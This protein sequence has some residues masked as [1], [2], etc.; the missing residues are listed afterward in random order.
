MRLYLLDRRCRCRLHLGK[1]LRPRFAPR[2]R[3]IKRRVQSLRRSLRVSD[4]RD[5]RLEARHLGG[6]DIDI[7]EAQ[8]PRWARPAKPLELQARADAEQHIRVSPASKACRAVEAERM[9]VAHDAP[10]APEGND[11]RLKSL[12]KLAHRGARMLRAA[13]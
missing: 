1:F 4:Q 5:I 11:R 10:T 8:R 2:P 9:I 7:D 13:A 3:A 12:R 6:V